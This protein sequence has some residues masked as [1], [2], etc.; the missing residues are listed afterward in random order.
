M[1]L[2]IESLEQEGI[3]PS[4]WQENLSELDKIR[5]TKGGI[6]RLNPPKIGKTQMLRIAFNLYAEKKK[7]PAISDEE[8][9][10]LFTPTH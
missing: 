10:A 1:K 4:N 5:G 7:V 3:T 2:S 8:M 6:L 9:M